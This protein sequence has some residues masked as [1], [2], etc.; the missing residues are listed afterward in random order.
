MSKLIDRIKSPEPRFFK[1]LFQWASIVFAFAVTILGAE[2]AL[3]AYLPEFSFT[4]TGWAS[5][6]FKNVAVVSLAIMAA[7][8]LAKTND[9]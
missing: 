6:I 4:L 8:K 3:Q 2:A 1:I 9:Q 5:T 7:C